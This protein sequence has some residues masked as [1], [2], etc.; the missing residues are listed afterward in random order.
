MLSS[1]FAGIPISSSI[2][3]E[4]GVPQLLNRGEQTVRPCP[5]QVAGFKS[6]WWPKSNRNGG[7]LQIGIPGRIASEFARG[8]AR[9]TYLKSGDFSPWDCPYH[10]PLL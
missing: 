9:R 5:A 7:R 4:A 2:I 6:E 3:D 8:Y 10:L 1:R